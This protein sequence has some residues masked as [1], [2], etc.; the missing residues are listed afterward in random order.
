MADSTILI[1][2]APAGSFVEIPEN[3]SRKYWEIRLTTDSGQFEVLLVSDEQDVMGET[4]EHLEDSAATSS[5]KNVPMGGNS[6]DMNATA[7]YTTMLPHRSYS[8]HYDRPMTPESLTS[9]HSHLKAPE[10]HE[11]HM[12]S[13]PEF[14]RGHPIASP[15]ISSVSLLKSPRAHTTID[16]NLSRDGFRR[17][18]LPTVTP[19]ILTGADEPLSFLSAH[20]T[21]APGNDHTI[22]NIGLPL[23][24]Y[25]FLP[26]RSHPDVSMS[27][28]VNW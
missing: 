13:L 11:N 19:Y 25:G 6:H 18:E 22:E 7:S 5:L 1:F 14:I 12:S 26:Q 27:H 8:T 9:D 17:L 15:D 16:S 23:D 24:E 3:G 20:E 21:L 2:R 4:L 28:R 10:S